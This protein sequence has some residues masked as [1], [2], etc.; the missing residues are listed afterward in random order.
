MI[1]IVVELAVIREFSLLQPVCFG[2]GALIAV[3]A[4]IWGWPTLLAWRRA[5]A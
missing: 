3:S 4:V 5:T 1:W 2:I